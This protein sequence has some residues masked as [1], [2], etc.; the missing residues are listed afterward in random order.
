MKNIYIGVMTG[1]SVDAIDIAALMISKDDFRLLNAQSFQFL[2]ITREKILRIIRNYK[3]MN[4]DEIKSLDRELATIY[5]D[6]INKFISSSKIEKKNIVAIGLHG[7]TILHQPNAINP[8]SL[9]IGDGKI[10]RKITGISVVNDF[11]SEDIRSGGQG[12]P[13]APIFHNHFFGKTGIKRAVINIGGISNI[14]ILADEVIGYDIGPGNTL[15]DIWIK[16]TK[17]KNFDE[18]GQWA[19]SGN[20]NEK[21]LVKFLEDEFINLKPPK[22]TGTDYFN[23]SWINQKLKELDN[24]ISSSDIQRTLAE[25]TARIIART[26]NTE[27]GLNEVAVCGGGSG[28]KF[29]MQLVQNHSHFKIHQT[30]QWGMDSKW[31]ESS[32]FAYLAYLRI[33]NF[34]LDLSKITGSK[35]RVKLGKIRN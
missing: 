19:K 33:N 10:V 26:I 28:N 31:V 23:I 16:D 25:L 34:A 35:G 20:I 3:V 17:E 7:Q 11:R 1:T 12:A 5:G 13:L 30:N 24:Q 9:Q 21:L 8:M 32:G 15:M 2:K 22:S 27:N 14:S 29:L 4:Q 6:T 18:D